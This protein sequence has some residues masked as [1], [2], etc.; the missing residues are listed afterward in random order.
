M[1]GQGTPERIADHR[2]QELS[3]RL[4]RCLVKQDLK[5]K[6]AAFKRTSIGKLLNMLYIYKVMF[7]HGYVQVKENNV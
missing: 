1:F 6:K 2:H 3:L 7:I 5:N 4:N